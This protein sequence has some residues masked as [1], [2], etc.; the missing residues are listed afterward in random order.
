MQSAQPV[1]TSYVHE[2]FVAASSLSSHCAMVRPIE[3]YCM[4]MALLRASVRFVS[5]LAAS[6][7]KRRVPEFTLVTCVSRPMRSNC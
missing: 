7:S 3:S 6:Y 1:T 4:R 5:L 2:T